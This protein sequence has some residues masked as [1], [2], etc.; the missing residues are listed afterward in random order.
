[1]IFDWLSVFDTVVD[2]DNWIRVRR[3]IGIQCR[4][5]SSRDQII[6]E[7]PSRDAGLTGPVQAG[8]RIGLQT[9]KRKISGKGFIN[10]EL[11]PPWAS[12]LVSEPHMRHLV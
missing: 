3:L 2:I 5:S 11:I 1:M 6:V 10:P 9:D 12:D 7:I 4:Y 8:V